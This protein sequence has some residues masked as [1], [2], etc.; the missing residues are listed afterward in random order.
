MNEVKTIN[1]Q[2]VETLALDAGFEFK[3]GSELRPY[4]YAFAWA[5]EKAV[6][7][8]ARKRR[9]AETVRHLGLIDSVIGVIEV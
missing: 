2:M 8:N 6:L 7:N 3:E 4:V 5:L 9:N 1:R